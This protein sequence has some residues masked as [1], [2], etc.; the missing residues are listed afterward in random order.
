MNKFL[1]AF[2]TISSLLAGNAGAQ[3]FAADPALFASL[4]IEPIPRVAA[5]TKQGYLET[6]RISVGTI[7]KSHHFRDNDYNETHHGIY[8]HVDQW[9]VGTYLNSGDEQSVFVTYNPE[10]YSSK[11]LAVNL[12]AGVADGYEGWNMAQDE[13]LPIV[14]V[15]ANWMNIRTML[16]FD[17]VAFGF[18]L[19][20][21]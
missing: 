9:S 12:V 14:G 1:A 21:N 19:P 13:Y 17:L 7:L 16:S 6:T 3:D 2:L 5:S 15:S 10:I 20:M 18:E 8:L 11:A 4:E